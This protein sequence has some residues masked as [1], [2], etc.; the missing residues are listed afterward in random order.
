MLQIVARLDPLRSAQRGI[1]EIHPRV[2]D[3]SVVERR[4][5]LA[6]HVQAGIGRLRTIT[7]DFVERA[8]DHVG[9]K[10]PMDFTSNAAVGGWNRGRIDAEVEQH[11]LNP[12]VTDRFE[13][14][15]LIATSVAVASSAL[16]TIVSFHIDG[17]TGACIVLIQFAVFVLAFLFAP[18]RGLVA[19][20]S[21]PRVVSP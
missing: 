19:N 20:W 21:R 11:G 3:P 12:A 2:R 15:L 17:A 9:L 5:S 8:E 6:A 4:L 7:L 13:R 18:K 16:G 14:M 10:Q 1:V